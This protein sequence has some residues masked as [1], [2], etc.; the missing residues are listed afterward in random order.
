MADERTTLKREIDK[1][2]RALKGAPVWFFKVHGGHWQRVG[3]PDYIGV[4]KG[5]FVSVELKHP[6]DMNSV[7]SPVQRLV[8]SYIMD[9]GGLHF[10]CRSRQCFED[11]ITN[12][13]HSSI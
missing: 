4:V 13:M 3:I 9:A 7:S 2:I 11:A 5:R 12:V 1:A 8:A 10:V 6:T